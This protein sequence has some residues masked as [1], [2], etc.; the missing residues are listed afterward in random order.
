MKTLDPSNENIYLSTFRVPKMDCPSEENLIRMQLE[1]IETGLKLEF[2]IPNRIVRITHKSNSEKIDEAMR[3][4]GFGSIME[5]TRPAEA[6]E[7]SAYFNSSQ[8]ENDQEAK[9]LRLLLAINAFM[10][11]FELTVGWIG[12][13]TGLIA[14]S[15]DMF[16]DA[17]VYGMA[18]FAV[19]KSAA[20]KLNAAHLS[21]WLQMILAFGALSEVLRRFIFGSEP[22]SILMMGIGC[23]ALIAN[24]SCLLLIAK[25][26]DSGAHMRASWIF[27][28]NDVIAN[29]GVI[30]AGTLVWWTGSRFPDL[31][32]GLLI[33]LVVLSGAIRILKIR[34]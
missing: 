18:L 12:Q 10:F 20:K 29:I 9:T 32:I 19:G 1:P 23:I 24:V 5:E 17:A 6:Q 2:D 22:V 26:K 4:C 31:A 13:S 25:K 15:L 21:G 3:S 33:G 28:A 16:A 34:A 14:D 8:S 30:I 27:S 11:F 7:K